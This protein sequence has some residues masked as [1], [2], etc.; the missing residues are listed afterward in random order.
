MAIVQLPRQFKAYIGQN[1]P[2]RI[3]G[4]KV[5]IVI[6]NLVAQYPV[7]APY[8]LTDEGGF[9]S[10]INFYKNGKDIRFLSEPDFLLEND[11]LE[12]ILAT[13]GG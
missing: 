3:S 7:L 5:S 11:I 10:F 13:A 12:I 9:N 8:L 1:D 6:K 2:L 4:G